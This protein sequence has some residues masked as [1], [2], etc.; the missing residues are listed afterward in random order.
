MEMLQK[1]TALT[2]D[3]T[4]DNVP[5]NSASFKFKQKKT[6]SIGNRGTKNVITMVPLKY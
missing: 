1:E 3:G 4:L 6:G 5:G 2:D